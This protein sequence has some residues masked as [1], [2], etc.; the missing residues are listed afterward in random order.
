MPGVSAS[1]ESSSGLY[2]RGGTPDQTLVLYDGFTVYHV[3]HLFGFFSAFNYNA[4]K[5]IQLY[6]G[7]FDAK[8]GGRISGVAEITGKEG[9]KKKLNA[10]VDVGLLSVNGFVETPIGKKVTFLAA[11]R[12]SWK[13]PLYTKIFD[14]FTAERAVAG[15]GQGGGPGGFPGGGRGNNFVTTTKASSYFYDLN[16]KLTFRPTKKDIVSLSF[17]NG[18]DNMDN[19]TTTDLSAVAALAGRNINLNSSS[20][21]ISDWGNTGGSLKWSK[22][23]SEKFYSNTLL[24]YSD[25]FSNRD[26]SRNLNIQ[27]PGDAAPQALKLGQYETNTVSDL[28]GKIDFEY[29]LNP[30]NQFDFG[31]QYASNT[32]KYN[33]TQNDTIT[34]LDRNDNGQILSAYV[35]DQLRFLNGSLVIKPGL[36][37]NYFSST[38]KSYVEPRLSANW[39]ITKRFKLKGA[40]GIYHQFIKQI[41]REDIT[42]G[43]RSFWILANNSTLPVTSSIHYIVGAAYETPN[44]LIDVELYQK[45]NTDISEYS[46]RFVPQVGRTLKA[47]ETFFNG[48]ETIRGIDILAQRKFGALTGWLGYTLAEAKRNIA[49]FSDKPYYSDQDVRHQVKAVAMYTLKKVDF[50]LTWILATGRPYTSILGA[51]D[52]KLLD[53]SFRS[54]TNPSDKNANRFAN[55]HRMD[56]SMTFNMNKNLSITGSVFNAYNRTNIWYKRFQI[57]REQGISFLQTTDVTYL[58]VTPNI[59]LSWKLR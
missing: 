29:K 15:Q 58:G 50:S 37:Y 55:Y 41:N 51:Y 53:G 56:A 39:N 21:D 45:Q 42:Q 19:S 57:V 18:T 17:F 12:R 16:A 24:S 32:V 40:G 28:T 43:N 20:N 2:V 59:M 9:D 44:Y 38:Q 36:R 7:G 8:F 25:Y 14:K 34:V 46:L 6:K 47:S 54:Y 5:D 33:Y 30:T 4:I 26:N 23:W 52:L 35:Q 48:D 10:G 49:A 11:A 1:N 22:K 13:G 27:R 3:D 31:M